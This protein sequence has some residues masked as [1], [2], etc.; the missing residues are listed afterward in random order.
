MFING[1]KH[2]FKHNDKQYSSN[3]IIIF[4][5][6]RWK[7]LLE[8]EWIEEDSVFTMI[9]SANKKGTLRAKLTTQ[10][11]KF[12]SSLKNVMFFF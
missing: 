7:K 3:N 4:I 5:I 9:I 10:N 2:I 8:S 12:D 1:E 11:K 6:L